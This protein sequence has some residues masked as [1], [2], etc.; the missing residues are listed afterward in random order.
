[1]CNAQPAVKAA[2]ARVAPSHD[3]DGLVQVVGWLLN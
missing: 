1:M 2:A 3:D